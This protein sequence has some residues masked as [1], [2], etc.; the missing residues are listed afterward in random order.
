MKGALP[1]RTRKEKRYVKPWNEKDLSPADQTHRVCL[2]AIAC[3]Y[4]VLNRGIRGGAKERRSD[5]V[6]RLCAALDRERQSILS[7]YEREPDAGAHRQ[8]ARFGWMIFDVG[9]DGPRPWLMDFAEEVKALL[10]DHRFD[11][12]LAEGLAKGRE[13]IE[14]TVIGASLDAATK[15]L[16]P[17][18]ARKEAELE[19]EHAAGWLKQFE[20]GPFGMKR[21]VEFLRVAGLDALNR[22]L[23][24]PNYSGKLPDLFDEWGSVE[25]CAG[26]TV[27]ELGELQVMEWY[28]DE[29]PGSLFALYNHWLPS[30]YK[31][32][33]S[34]VARYASEPELTEG[35]R[36]FCDELKDW[37]EVEELASNWRFYGVVAEN[38]GQAQSRAQALVRHIQEVLSSK[39]G[40]LES[41]RALVPQ[42]TWLGEPA[43]LF[44]L[45]E[46]L[47]GKNWLAL[48]MNGGKYSRTELAKRLSAAFALEG[49]ERI[50]ESTSIQYMKPRG[51]RPEGTYTFKIG[52]NPNSEKKRV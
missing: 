14:R 19:L 17:E 33:D 44:N 40:D 3:A 30:Y 52:K 36:S 8:G 46:E 47:V 48:P 29:E 41:Q 16:I 27:A 18:A 7:P 26:M 22:S 35:L 2:E 15:R 34:V 31:V 10:I 21:D 43:D 12:V 6:E 42:F 45:V 50:A 28:E 4:L 32:L 49:G 11:P 24:R 13:V 5:K 9:E 25:N 23:L 51:H 39:T 37:R 38:V 1:G 20:Q